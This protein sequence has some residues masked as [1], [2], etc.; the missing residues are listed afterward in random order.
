MLLPNYV[1]PHTAWLSHREVHQVA[2]TFL[3]PPGVGSPG[4]GLRSRRWAELR[5]SVPGHVNPPQGLCSRVDAL[6]P[7]RKHPHFLEGVLSLPAAHIPGQ[8]WVLCSRKPARTA[9]GGEGR[10]QTASL[11]TY[12]VSALICERMLSRCALPWAAGE[13]L[14]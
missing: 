3:I 13:G 1:G 8:T 2:E 11:Q 9:Q 6:T 7:D 4:K 12:F 5:A 10:G 14:R